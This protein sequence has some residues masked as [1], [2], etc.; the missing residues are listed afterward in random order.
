M[1]FGRWLYDEW[2]ALRSQVMA[3]GN[4]RMAMAYVADRQRYLSYKA[5][6]RTGANGAWRGDRR[7]AD[8]VIRR[9]WKEV[10]CRARDLAKNSPYVSGAIEKI[11]DNV[12]FNGIR[13]QVKVVRNGKADRA[14]ARDLER[15]WKRW[16]KAIDLTE[17]QE[18]GLRH[19]W[20]DGGLFVHFYV[21]VDLMEKGLPPLGLEL[22]ELDHLDRTVDGVQPNGN[23]ARGGIEYDK[24]GRAVAYHLFPEHPGDTWMW[25]GVQSR[26][27]DARNVEHV[28]TR[29]RISQRNGMSWLASVIMAMHN[30]DEYQSSE[31]IAM[32]LLSAFAFFVET[33][34]DIGDAAL[35][36]GAALNPESGTPQSLGDLKAGDFIESGQVVT[37]PMGAKVNAAGYDRPGSNYEAWTKSQLRGGSAGMG[38]AYETFTGDL[39]ETTYSGGRQG[40]QVERRAYQRQQGILNRKINDPVFDRWLEFVQLSD[41][42]AIDGADVEVSWLCP[43]WPWV[44]PRNDSLSARI[45]LEMG[46]TTLT[47][48]CADRGLDFEEVQEKRVEE[49]NFMNE[50][51]LTQEE[52]NAP[53]S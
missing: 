26:R 45:E 13:P 12:V 28:F 39:T 32:R 53:Q 5:A 11:C 40:L 51:G 47:K 52:T 15:L 36:G 38:V 25:A 30:F 8:A 44:D 35:L 2:T 37:V 34:F 20:S 42:A 27:V 21:D 29:K 22:L 50:I 48:L 41:L 1:G 16:A 43:G 6:S 9:E 4:P 23:T 7:S 31:Q 14:R 46:V 10:A 18:L 24:R 17:K 3:L 33:P 49:M 19:L